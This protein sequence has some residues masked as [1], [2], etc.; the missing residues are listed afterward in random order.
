M[1][2]DDSREPAELA[3]LEPPPFDETR[4]LGL[5]E[6]SLPV[7]PLRSP[8]ER[9]LILAILAVALGALDLLATSLR[10]DLGKVPWAVAYGPA[11]LEL[12]AGAGALWLAM[13]W[14]VPGSGER[15]SRSSVLVATAMGLAL[16]AALAAPHFVPQ[17]HPGLCVGSAPGMGLRCTGW[18]LIIAVPILLVSL[19]F[20]FRGAAVSSAFAGAL[21]GLGAGLISDAAMHLHCPAVDP[22]HTITWHL[23][24]V[25][26][27]A[28]AGALIGRL[29]PR[30]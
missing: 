19:W 25:A 24:A 23:G 12:L 18:Q 22:S 30:W 7:R 28:A 2:R 21:A 16:A 29:L 4:L 1:H 15:F 20:I 14:S 10:T 27:L 6:Q 26:L 3:S 9:S 17:D 13:R 8:L 5:T 11:L